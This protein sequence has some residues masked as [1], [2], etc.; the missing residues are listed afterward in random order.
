M[1]IKFY[2]SWNKIVVCDRYFYQFFFDLFGGLSKKVIRVFPKPDITFFL[3]G[4]LDVF[5]SRINSP[6]DAMVSRDYYMSATNLY[7]E[8]ADFGKIG[9]RFRSKL[10]AF[11]EQISHPLVSWG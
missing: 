8:F 4:D 7:R 5:Y 2:L 6:S 3:D 10:T 1:V 11:S 9:H